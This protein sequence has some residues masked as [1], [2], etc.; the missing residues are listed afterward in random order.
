MLAA[1][2]PAVERAVGAPFDAGAGG[3]E[4]PRL[5]Q[6]HRHG[7]LLAGADADRDQRQRASTTTRNSAGTS[8]KPRTPVRAT[9][10]ARHVT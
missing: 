1:Q 6:A 8:A 7:V 9:G 4:R 5:H 3:G 10:R 2:L